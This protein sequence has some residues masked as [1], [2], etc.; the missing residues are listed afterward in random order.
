[1]LQE[2]IHYANTKMKKGWIIALGL[3][4]VGIIGAFVW[5]NNLKKEAASEPGAYDNTLKPRLELSRFDFTDIS[6]DT[7]KLNMYL[8]IDNP[9]PV[10]L[11][12]SKINYVISIADTPIIEDEY[13]KGITIKSGDSSMVEL[14]VMILSKKFKGVLARL[15]RDGVDSTNYRIKTSFDLDVPILGEKTFTVIA[16][17]YLPTYH[18][19]T[20]KVEDIDFGKLNLKEQD[21]A[22][23]VSVDNRNK[24]PYKITDTHY[25]VTIN[26]KQIAEGYQPEPIIIPAEAITPVVF[27]VTGNVGKALSVL[28][29]IIFD[30]KNTPYAIDFRCKIIDK[31]KSM[32]F[33]NSKFVATI[34]GTM[35]DFKK[36]K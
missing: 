12:A 35:D 3:L 19:P 34:R 15:E 5:Y 16:N 17:R 25:T 4:L 18:I 11:K 9:L 8:L 2:F 13:R 20:I 6:D 27:P 10:E 21:I 22:A 14:P 26:G 23:K 33:Q 29:K 1:M 7:I 24:F 28:P 30:K 32:S 36:K 31:N